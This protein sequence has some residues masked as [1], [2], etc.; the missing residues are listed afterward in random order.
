MSLLKLLGIGKKENTNS[1]HVSESEATR[2]LA[3]QLSDIEPSKARYIACFAYLLSRVA[4]ADMQVSNV[5]TKAMERVLENEAGLTVRE[6]SLVVEMTRNRG[7]VF[8]GTDDF[9]VTREFNNI[10]SREQ[11]LMLL[12]CLFA[13][14]AADHD[15]SSEEDVEI[16][17]IASELNLDH[18]DFIAARV[19]FKSDLSVLHKP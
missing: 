10:A 4:R 11:K 15:V 17:Q 12:R 1:V 13:V 7:E 9:I 14:A 5:E 19:G 8:G 2:R 3:A 16:R 6:A 18:R